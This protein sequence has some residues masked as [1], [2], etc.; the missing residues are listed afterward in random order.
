MNV[1]QE[2]VRNTVFKRGKPDDLIIMD[3]T[4]QM[5]SRIKYTLERGGCQGG[6]GCRERARGVVIK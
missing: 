1:I 5:G 3:T 4:L 2:N 6:G